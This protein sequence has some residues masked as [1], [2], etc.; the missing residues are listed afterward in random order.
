MKIKDLYKNVH[1]SFIH[2]SLKKKWKQPKYPS[3]G[4]E[5]NIVW[6]PKGYPPWGSVLQLDFKCKGD[7]L[8]KWEKG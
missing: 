2:N 7:F 1:N 8:V 3:M 6:C 4:D 5:I